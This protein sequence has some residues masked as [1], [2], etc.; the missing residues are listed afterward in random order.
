MDCWKLKSSLGYIVSS[1]LKQINKETYLDMI[2][3][4]TRQVKEEKKKD[5]IN[6]KSKI[7]I[8]ALLDARHKIR[9]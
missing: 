4:T 2:L 9:K 3:K 7:E 1:L 6:F 8:L 5:K